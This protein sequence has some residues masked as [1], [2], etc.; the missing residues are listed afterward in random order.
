METQAICTV[1]QNSQMYTVTVYL[2]HLKMRANYHFMPK[3]HVDDLY[4]EHSGD[5]TELVK[6]IY[7]TDWGPWFPRGDNRL[8][9][10]T[11]TVTSDDDDDMVRIM[12]TRNS[13]GHKTIIV[14]REN[15]P[16]Y[17]VPKIEAVICCYMSDLDDDGDFKSDMFDNVMFENV[18]Y[19]ND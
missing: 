14:Y 16:R 12:L 9:I 8:F 1:W 13:K 17:T 18:E 6:Q 2:S 10:Q 15:T 4:V 3:Y 7:N 11:I 19:I 5:L